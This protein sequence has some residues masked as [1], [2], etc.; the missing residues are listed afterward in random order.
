MGIK[1]FSL[2]RFDEY[3]LTFFQLARSIHLLLAGWGVGL[4]LLK[5]KVKTNEKPSTEDLN[6]TFELPVRQ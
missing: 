4:I 3:D 5:M 6:E 2:F 1:Y